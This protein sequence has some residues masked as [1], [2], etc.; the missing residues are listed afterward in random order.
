M[1]SEMLTV[2]LR[3]ASREDA[4]APLALPL[5]DA[6]A[7]PAALRAAAEAAGFAGAAG[8]TVLLPERGVMLLGTG[9]ARRPLD[10]EEAGGHAAAAAGEVRRFG[11]DARGLPPVAAASLAA[12]ACL[13]AWRFNRYRGKP[14]PGPHRLD[15]IVDDPEAVV[16]LWDRA[17]AGVRGCLLA[18]DLSMEPGNALT[19]RAFTARLEA[20]AEYGIAVDVLGRK[21][22]AREGL[23]GLLAVGGGSENPPRLAVLRWRGSVAAPPLVFIGK[24][25]CFDTGGIS[26]KGAAGMEAMKADMAGAAAC[27]GAM[28]A[29]ALRRSPAP[30]I[31]ILA[32]AENAVGPASYRPGDVLR[33][34]SGRT[35]EVIDTDAEGR[36]VLADALHY[37]Q[38]FQPGAVLDLATLTGSIV[39]ALGAHRAG[40]FGTDERLLAQAQ[41]AG[42]AVGELLWPMPIGARHREDLASAIADLKQCASGTRQPDACHA[43]AF[44]RE[45]AGGLPWA[46]LDIAGVDDRA[47]AVALGPRG[48]SGFGARLLDALVAMYFEH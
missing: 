3:R 46:H 11:I 25:I 5:S 15:L 27:A 22:L 44:L 12:G 7:V 23:G 8:Q 34:G 39:T 41:A 40:L 6:A 29:L 32:L 1:V 45:F 37:A 30:A 38:R 43:A 35:V 13:R 21:R 10:W 42:E 20:L 9:A 19:T 16:P 33:M 4:R 17:S 28:L 36:L 14:T 2:K 47:E 26:I 48:P 18:R 24:G 31:A